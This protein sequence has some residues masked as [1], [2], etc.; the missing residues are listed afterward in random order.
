MLN[1]YFYLLMDHVTLTSGNY[2]YISKMNDF[3]E[4]SEESSD[5]SNSSNL[6]RN[7]EPNK[8]LILGYHKTQKMKTLFKK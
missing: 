2:N 3:N 8:I 7:P 4:D 6:H 5:Q 1:M